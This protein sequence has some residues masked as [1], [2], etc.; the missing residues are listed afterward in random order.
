MRN[1]KNGHKIL[2]KIINNG[3]EIDKKA[4]LTLHGPYFEPYLHLLLTPLESKK[5]FFISNGLK[6]GLSAFFITCQTNQQN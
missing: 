5:H 3:S 1:A 2:P 6:R 4:H